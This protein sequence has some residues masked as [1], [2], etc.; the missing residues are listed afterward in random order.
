MNISTY[1]TYLVD[2]YNQ[3]KSQFIIYQQPI[4]IL[5]QPPVNIDLNQLNY[6]LRSHQIRFEIITSRNG[7]SKFHTNYWLKPMVYTQSK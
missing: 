3:F 7:C 6:D 5:H 1:K 4:E 2:C